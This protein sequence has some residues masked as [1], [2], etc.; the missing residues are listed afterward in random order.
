MIEWTTT[1]IRCWVDLCPGSHLILIAYLK[2]GKIVILP[3]SAS[4]VAW[5]MTSNS[6]DTSTSSQSVGSIKMSCKYSVSSIGVYYIN[7]CGAISYIGC[8]SNSTIPYTYSSFVL[9]FTQEVPGIYE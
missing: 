7:W 4:V 3:C 9:E 6:I 5:S 1:N 8:N 2:D